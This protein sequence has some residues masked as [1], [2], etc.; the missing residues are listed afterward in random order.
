[1]AKI[2]FIEPSGAEQIV[3]IP[4]GWTVMQGAVQNGIEGI[5]GECGGSCA[6]A[7]CHCYV[8]EEFLDALPAAGETEEAMLE[9]TASERR[10]NSR[11]SCQIRVSEALDGLVLR[12][13][14]AQS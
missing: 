4:I 9:C 3:D 6:C 10:S 2:T 11:L 1:M 13:P 8:E 7:T 14:E 12:L 5:E